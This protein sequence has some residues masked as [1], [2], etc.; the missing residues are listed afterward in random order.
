[1]SGMKIPSKFIKVNGICKLNPEFLE[2]K[3]ETGGA[4]AAMARREDPID[5]MT[6]RITII[7]G[8]D[9]VAKDRNLLGKKTSS[10]PFVQILVGTGKSYD[11][12]GQTKTIYK[13]LSPQWNETVSAQ[14]KFIHHGGSQLRF[15][16][17]DE[18][19][20]SN[21]DSMGFV[22][23]PLVWKDSATSPQWYEIPKDSAKNAKGKIQLQI[24]C[25]V[26]RL[27]GMSSYV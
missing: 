26:H 3:K 11:R 1:M 22:T 24:Q 23:L 4:D 19:K 27:Q 17:Y 25:K 20:L 7:Q 8:S 18:D 13:N 5:S 6:L 21:P 9:L 15:H 12:L 16:I 2:W 14:V 10:D